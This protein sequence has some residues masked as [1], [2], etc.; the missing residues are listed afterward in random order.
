MGRKQKSPIIL[1]ELFVRY[2]NDIELTQEKINSDK[3]FKPREMFLVDT[4]KEGEGLVE[5]HEKI[6]GEFKAYFKKE[7]ILNFPKLIEFA[8]K[9]DFK[10]TD[11]DLLGH[12][13]T[14]KSGDSLTFY[15]FFPVKVVSLKKL[16]EFIE[17]YEKSKQ[18][19]DFEETE[20]VAYKTRY[21]DKNKI[22]H[23]PHIHNHVF[24]QKRYVRPTKTLRIFEILWENRKHVVSRDVIRE[25]TPIKFDLFLKRAKLIEAKHHMSRKERE[26]LYEEI[27]TPVTNLAKQGFPLKISRAEGEILLKVIDR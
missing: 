7:K 22:L 14:N 11:E 5:N 15:R 1:N 26:S 6:F 16:K 4:L 10:W 3:S 19:K 23:T 27:K 13:S 8:T 2:L 25:G 9:Y 12:V 20:T 24:R 21:D 18:D 17:K